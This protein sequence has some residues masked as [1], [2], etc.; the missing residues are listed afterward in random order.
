M[1][2][3]QRA[4][5][6]M[7]EVVGMPL[8]KAKAILERAGLV[9]RDTVFEES[10]EERNTV[11]KQKPAR[12][13]MVYAG[14]TALLTISRESYVKWLPSLFQRNDINGQ[15]FIRDFLWIIQHL[16]ATVEEQLD[17]V[18]RFVDSYECP[19]EFLPWL[20]SWSAMVIDQAWPVE[21]KRR[22]IRKSVELY[23]VRGSIK[24]LRL[25]ISLFTGHEP[26][27]HENVWPFRGWRMGVTSEISI[28]TVILPT[29]NLAHVFVVE[30]PIAYNNVS[31]EE[32]ARIHDVIQRE[33]PANTEYYLRFAAEEQTSVLRQF[34]SI[35]TQ[36]GIGVGEAPAEAITSEED[37]QKALEASRRQPTKSSKGVDEAEES[38]LP[39]AR[40][41]PPLPKAPRAD[42]APIEGQERTRADSSV[43]QAATQ[44]IKTA[45]TGTKT[46]MGDKK[47]LD[48]K[49]LDDD[50][51]AKK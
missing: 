42:L 39:P 41:R 20:A 12:G 1:I 22:L 36:S 43:M 5:V 48:E 25:F 35:G 26:V 21:K 19:E 34:F 51:G 32:V 14:E 30:M 3:Q 38:L 10:Y 6:R 17:S 4:L 49:K 11:L 40:K 8:P 2:A 24:G 33:K 50:K 23:R 27:I 7:P 46:M 13:Q 31:M 47:S 15:N 16:F 29:V 28:D 45:D 9:V 37:L 18:H 44:A